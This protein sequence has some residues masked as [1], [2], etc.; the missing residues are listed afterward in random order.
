MTTELSTASGAAGAGIALHGDWRKA[1]AQAIERARTQLDD[2][3]TPPDEESEQPPVDLA[4]LFASAHYTD[5]FPE[6][7]TAAR[8]AARARLLVGCSG[9][10][11]IGPKREIEQQPALSVL[12]LRL[13]GVQLTPRY[14]TQESLDVA[15]ADDD[16][17]DQLAPA[18]QEALG[19]DA[20]AARAW[21]LFADPFRLDVEAL[22]VG[23]A[24]T[25][26]DAAVV[27]GLASGHQWQRKTH[28]FI[29]DGD[30]P[31]PVRDEGAL[32]IGLGGDWT[33]RT[34]VAQGCIPIG[35]PWT[36]TE[37]EGPII[38]TIAGRPALDV[39]V[40]TLEA[41]PP[42]VQRR[43]QRGGPFVG[44]AVDEHRT[45]L[46]SGDFL[47]RN[48]LGF[49]RERGVIAVGAHP[50]VGQTLQFH[51]RDRAAADEELHSML[52]A[53]ETEST[54]VPP[55]AALLCSCTGRGAGLFG[56]P[57]HDA[58]AVARALGPLPLAGFFC[59]GEIG[60]VGQ[61][62]YVHGYTASL[63]LLVYDPPEPTG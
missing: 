4:L 23:M 55:L 36:I 1:L 28:L 22:V 15:G 45:T 57:D 7:V 48:L 5:D 59:N 37:S 56:T 13:P 31:V 12:L 58:D 19:P 60:P 10:G 46:G 41:L 51:L 11:V 29:D 49:D 43:A 2:A 62:S 14:L 42:E 39:L 34:L 6:I 40:D 33:V 21:L 52:S 44:L 25:F 9:T 24:Q 16:G 20:D 18:L 53:V 17:E 30:Q 50:Q 26:P 63:A 47:V 54:A 8:S 3:T 61:R 38:H 32:L 27:G 35:E